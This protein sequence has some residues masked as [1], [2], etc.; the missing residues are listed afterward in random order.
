MNDTLKNLGFVP[1]FAQQLHELSVMQSRL[2]R[3]IS[4]QRS[5]IA[6]TCADQHRKV[7]L[8]V[9]LQQAEP[10]DRPTVGDWVILDEA[11]SRVERVL[12]RKSLFKRIGSG[13][14]TQFQLIAANIDVV[15]IVTSCNEEFNE[16]RL[17]RYLALCSEAGAMPVIVL[18]KTDLAG[19]I[20]NYIQRARSV[21]AGVAVEQINALDARTLDDV[22]GWIDNSAT[23]A[24]LGSSGVGKSTL[25]NALAEHSLAAT[26]GIRE[27]DKK[28][29][30]TTTHRELYRLA[31]GGLIIDVPGMRELRVADV[32]Q[33]LSHVF[34]DIEGLSSHCQFSDCKH[35]NEPGCAV[36]AA[37][38]DGKIDRRRLN[39]FHKLLREN[40]FA[41]ASLAEKRAK[42][43]SFGKL[44]KGVKLHKQ[45]TGRQ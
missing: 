28:G 41:N 39:S 19:D 2:G 18:S 20:S 23:I 44:I 6:V 34:E 12:E 26:G 14:T 15:F 29:R 9:K 21:Q 22:K 17:E 45:K 30:H 31:S 13:N 8:S 7:E 43:R 27:H 38:E 33:A 4:V 32:G 5:V 10:I 35:I 24:L 40:E 25:L 11:L 16:S 3:V 1:F 42:D 37:I 36:L